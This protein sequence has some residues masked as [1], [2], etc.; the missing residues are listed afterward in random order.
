MLKAADGDDSCPFC[1]C[2]TF[3]EL[4]HDFEKPLLLSQNHAACYTLFNGGVYLPPGL[5]PEWYPGRALV[6]LSSSG[7]RSPYKPIV[8]QKKKIK[9]SQYYTQL[10]P[11]L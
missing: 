3:I 4:S 7:I 9:N 8:Q 1:S 6:P 5:V 10:S 2:G 11:L